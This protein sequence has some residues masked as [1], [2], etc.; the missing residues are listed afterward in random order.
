MAK[1]KIKAVAF[2]GSPHGR[3]GATSFQIESLF[4]G[5]AEAGAETEQV[6]LREYDILECRG[7]FCSSCHSKTPGKCVIKDDFAVLLEKFNAAD[8]VIMGTPLFIDNMT[9]IMKTF[10]D[11]FF[12]TVDPHFATD[13]NGETVHKPREGQRDKEIIVVSSCGY[14]EKTHFEVLSLIFKRAA[15]N[16]HWKIVGKIYKPTGILLVHPDIP[17]S[18]RKIIGRHYASQLA[19]IGL[20]L[21]EGRR[22]EAKKIIDRS[23]KGL[24]SPKIY[25]KLVNMLVDQQTRP[26]IL[27]P[28]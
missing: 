14:P 22:E 8:I 18:I 15:R 12:S 3:R 23:C 11:R 27:T 21:A 28:K 4:R 26:A 10:I 9:G 20:A 19:K 2:N 5:M 25:R 24:L 6:F 1:G 13:E 7:A 16:L 17:A